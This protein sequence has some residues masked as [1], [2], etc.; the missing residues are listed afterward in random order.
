MAPTQK[1]IILDSSETVCLPLES[2][3][4]APKKTRKNAKKLA[5]VGTGE[6]N[7]TTSPVLSQNMPISKEKKSKQWF[8]TWNN[9]PG[10]AGTVISEKFSL[11]EK[12][13][14]Q[15]EIG[16]EGTKHIQG[17]VL[18]K[19]ARSFDAMKKLL[20][21]E[22]HW[23]KCKSMK[24]ALAYCTKEDSKAPGGFRMVKGY[25]V[26]VTLDDEFLEYTPHPWQLKVLE[27]IKTKPDK[28]KIYWFW[29]PNGGAGKTV[30]ATHICDHNP[31]TLYVTGKCADIKAGVADWCK[32]GNP[33]TIVIWDIPRT[34]EGHI[35]YEA[36]ESVK[37]GILYSGKY[38]SGMCRFNK[39][40]I[41]IFSNHEPDISKL[42][43][44]RWVIEDL[45]GTPQITTDPAN[46]PNPPDFTNHI[47]PNSAVFG[48][49][50]N[51]FQ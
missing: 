40:H 4:K 31:S 36:L 14:F 15:E 25:V 19:N 18:W 43:K 23:E 45:R 34:N 5:P 51:Y 27:L 2:V 50:T 44:D 6:G 20:S 49:P 21:D 28:R 17:V 46:Q 24:E 39:P 26:P 16:E 7:T 42:S 12:F 3:Q 32:A 41:I 22:V 10:T 13:A 9:Y 33:P 30:L 37:N 11:A 8:F 1:N 38:E 35:S 47:E 29:E 48:L